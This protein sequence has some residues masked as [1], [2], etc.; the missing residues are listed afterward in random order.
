MHGT[1][2]KKSENSGFLL[3]IDAIATV[4]WVDNNLKWTIVS[5][6]HS[7]CQHVIFCEPPR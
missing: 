4:I 1:T 7:F 2:V 5:G 6:F 3:R